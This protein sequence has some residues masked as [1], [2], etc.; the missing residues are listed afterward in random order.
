VGGS[1]PTG[2]NP[3]EGLPFF[4]DLAK[5][6]ASSGP[7]HWDAARQFALAAATGG[8][9]EDNPDPLERMRLE[10]LGSCA[11]RP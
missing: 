8:T 9:A 2:G 11:S 6:L 3:F 7:V 4:G 5:M 1:G 10:E